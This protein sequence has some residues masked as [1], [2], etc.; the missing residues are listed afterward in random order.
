MRG[1]PSSLQ[2]DLVRGHHEGSIFRRKRDGKWTAAVSMPNGRRRERAAEWHD[3]CRERAKELLKAL[4]EE[5]DAELDIPARRLT[6]AVYLRSWLA[7]MHARP[8]TIVAYRG[9]IENHIIPALGT[10]TLDRLTGA[11]IQ[12]WLD[13]LRY[14]PATIAKCRAVL[15]S[16]LNAAVRRRK[17]VRNP[18]IGTESVHVPAH[19]A[20]TLTASQAGTLLAGTDGTFGALWAVLLGSGLRISEALALTWDHFDGESIVVRY[21]LVRRN[22]EWSRV[23][24][25]AARSVETQVALGAAF[26]VSGNAIYQVVHGITW[27]SVDGG[28]K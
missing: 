25:K 22:G 27:R 4:I 12:R 18:L 14:S 17:L 3:N 19:R 2:S 26:G 28:G 11:A 8:A 16:A 5:R 1:S 10:T 21:Q 23:P 24:T 20:A 13:S 6:L 9:V 7:D 15:R